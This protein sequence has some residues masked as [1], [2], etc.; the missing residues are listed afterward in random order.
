MINFIHF[1][2]LLCLTQT[3]DVPNEHKYVCGMPDR[4]EMIFYKKAH[5]N[6]EKKYPAEQILSFLAKRKELS[7]QET[8]KTHKRGLPRKNGGKLFCFPSP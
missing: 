5:L 6:F 7:A 8:N 1:F 3:N 2:F 4:E